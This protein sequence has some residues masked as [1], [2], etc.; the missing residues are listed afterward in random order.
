MITVTRVLRDGTEIETTSQPTDTP[1]LT[2]APVIVLSG[3]DPDTAEQPAPI[4]APDQW[5]VLH[6][7]SVRPVVQLPLPNRVAHQV[8]RALGATGLDWTATRGEIVAPDVVDSPYL[9]AVRQAL[10]EVWDYVGWTDQELA[11]HLRATEVA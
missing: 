7:L 11:D 5:V 3:P 8:A 1:G 6:G 2:V 9:A 10:V 4:V